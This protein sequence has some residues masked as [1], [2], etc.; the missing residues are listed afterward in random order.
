[1]CPRH[2]AT[3]LFLGLAILFVVV[4]ALLPRGSVANGLTWQDDFN[5]L[6][7][8]FTPALIPF[9][10]AILSVVFGLV[11]FAVEKKCK[12]A[13]NFPLVLI[14]LISYMLAILAQETL[15]RF[16]WENLSAEH[17]GSTPLPL[18]P[19]ELLAVSLATCCLA[20]GLNI[21]WSL[22]KTS[23]VADNAR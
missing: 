7:L 14:H 17:A 9:A 4:G 19:G 10:A 8:F 2:L 11:Y 16:W 18:W 12:R 6:F 22:S 20:F 21:F 23:L 1:M 5:P 3:K 13:L 15:A